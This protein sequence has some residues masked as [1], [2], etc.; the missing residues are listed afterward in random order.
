MVPL[1][2]RMVTLPA[3]RVACFSGFGVSPEMVAWEKLSQWGTKNGILPVREGTR[4]FGFNDP[5]PSPGSPNYG[6]TFWVTIS[7]EQNCQGIQTLEYTGGQYVVTPCPAVE[8]IAEIW[9]RF[10]H[11]IE[12]SSYV[13]GPYQWLEEVF[14]KDGSAD[15]FDHFDLYMPIQ[16]A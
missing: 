10:N 14:L 12:Q 15:F 5:D 6:Y 1:N 11:W 16:K 4:I 13:Y 2:V 8:E 7:K 3:F 9:K